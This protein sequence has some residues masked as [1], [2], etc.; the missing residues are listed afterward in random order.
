MNKSRRF[1]RR[2]T[3]RK[4]KQARRA[5]RSNATLTTRR[6]T[7]SQSVARLFLRSYA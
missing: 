4:S 2:W 1:L 6:A 7:D 5:T 3:T